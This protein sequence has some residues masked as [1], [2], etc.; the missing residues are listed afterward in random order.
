MAALTDLYT[1]RGMK[2]RGVETC[3][4][5]LLVS[6]ML[7]SITPGAQAAERELHWDALNVEAHLNADGVLDVSEFDYRTAGGIRLEGVGV[8]PDKTISITRSDI[9]SR[10]DPALDLAKRILD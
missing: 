8:K 10:R 5:S 7:C 1:S 3:Y 6:L 4:L 9:Y 2:T